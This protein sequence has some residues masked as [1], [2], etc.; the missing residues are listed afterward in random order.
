M[1]VVKKEFG[2]AK[3]VKIKF[4]NGAQINLTESGSGGLLVDISGPVELLMED[5]QITCKQDI[6]VC[7]QNI[8]LETAGRGAV[9]I[10]SY[11]AR[12]VKDS[13]AGREFIKRQK[14][15]AENRQREIDM[16]KSV[17]GGKHGIA[18]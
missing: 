6:D 3:G 1:E 5:L 2:L 18:G 4:G 10:N 17:K 15:I 14:K 13:S 11:R 9:A 8:N 12:Q 16:Q 7:A